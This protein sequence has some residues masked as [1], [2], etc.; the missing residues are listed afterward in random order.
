MRIYLKP[1]TGHMTAQN[2]IFKDKVVLSPRTGLQ[3]IWVVKINMER[4]I[5]CMEL[6][7]K[8]CNNINQTKLT[9]PK[10]KKTQM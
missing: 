6:K 9:T 3:R 10:P 5:N 7:R 4:K 1:Y 8:H 2:M